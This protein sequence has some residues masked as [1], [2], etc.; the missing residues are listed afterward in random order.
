MSLRYSSVSDDHFEGIATTQYLL[1]RRYL[2]GLSVRRVGTQP[3]HVPCLAAM[4][5]PFLV[6]SWLSLAVLYRL[7]AD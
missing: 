7:V 6:L 1:D 3:F 2:M 5:L 4:T